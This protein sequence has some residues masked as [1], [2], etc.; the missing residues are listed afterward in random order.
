MRRLISYPISPDMPGWPGN[1]TYSA[2]PFE[3]MEQG[4]ADNTYTV[5]L[6]NHFGTHFDAPRHFTADGP[7]ISDLPF[8]TFFYSAP[9]LLDIPKGSRE[10]VEPE[11]LIPFE[12]QIGRCD[13]LMIR[14]GYARVRREDPEEYSHNSPAVSSRAARYLRDRFTG[15]LKAVALDFLSLATPH[16]DSGDGVLAHQIMLGKFQPGYICIIEDVDMTR[17]PSK[18]SAAAAVPLFLKGIDS[19]PVTMWAETEEQHGN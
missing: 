6:F 12:E 11:D 1:P 15:T 8:D 3:S 4:M 10:K 17:L 16:D 5:T 2:A 7:T 19:G 14:T 9:L 13:L 18:I